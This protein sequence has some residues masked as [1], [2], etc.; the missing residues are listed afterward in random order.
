MSEA[1]EGV[2]DRIAVV[3][4]LSEALSHTVLNTVLFGNPIPDDQ[5]TALVKA[6]RLLQEYGVPWPTVLDQALQEAADQVGQWE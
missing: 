5:A 1:A 6:A 4:R 3:L 2:S